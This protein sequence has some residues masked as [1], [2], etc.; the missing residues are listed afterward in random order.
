MNPPLTEDGKPDFGA[1]D[2]N[3]LYVTS[4][5]QVFMKPEKDSKVIEYNFTVF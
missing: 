3:V 5:D 4:D 2:P 1:L